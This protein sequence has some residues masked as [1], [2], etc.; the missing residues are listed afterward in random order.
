MVDGEVRPRWVTTVSGSFDHRVVDG[1]QVSRFIDF[2]AGPRSALVVNN[3]D[4]TQGMDVLTFLRDIGK[5]FSVNAMVQKESVRQRIEREGAGISY[6]E[7]SYQILQGM[8]FLELYRSYGCVLQT[9]GSDQWGNITAGTDLIR[10]LCAQDDQAESEDTSLAYGITFP[11]LV[12]SDGKK[13]GKSEGGAIW[14]DGDK[15][16][17]YHMYQ[18][19]L[20]TPDSDV[21]KFLKML[22]FLEMPEVDRIRDR[23]SPDHEDHLGPNGAQKILASEMGGRM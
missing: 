20:R 10:R 5:H 19:L 6:T 4:W 8:D 7:F 22:T 9:G 11:L 14:L 23:M 1:D 3:L 16:S 18:H 12:G 15:L 2:D 17:P 21:V 13:F